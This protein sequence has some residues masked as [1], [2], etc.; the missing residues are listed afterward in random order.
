MYIFD[1]NTYRYYYCEDKNIKNK[2]NIKKKSEVV[3]FLF[4]F[5]FIVE[6]DLCASP[7]IIFN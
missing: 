7:E 5:N 2:N 1:D 3:W 4:E 6:L